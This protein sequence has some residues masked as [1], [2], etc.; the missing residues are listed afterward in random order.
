[1]HLV[2]PL[3]CWWLFLGFFCP[4]THP[5]CSDSA[6]W[7]CIPSPRWWFSHVYFQSGPLLCNLYL[8]LDLSTH[9]SI[10][11]PTYL[12]IFPTAC[13]TFPLHCPRGILNFTHPKSN[14]WFL[15]PK[16][17]SSLFRKWQRHPWV[18][19]DSFP[20]VI[21]QWIDSTFKIC[22]NR[23]FRIHYLHD[24][25]PDTRHWPPSWPR[26]FSPWA[27]SGLLT[28]QYAKWSF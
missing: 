19:P 11:L 10:Y 20:H 5:A 1:M 2:F 17:N 9:L 27:S 28:S 25:Y 23:Y 15:T 16:A 7:L 21:R 6:S 18:S 22:V 26:S 14:S 13:S 24:Y 12:S 8:Y 4:L 3:F